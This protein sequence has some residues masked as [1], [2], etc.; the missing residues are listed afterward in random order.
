MACAWPSVALML[1][2]WLWRYESPKYL[3]AKGRT[4]EAEVVLKAIEKI[5]KSSAS[6][7]PVH[8]DGADLQSAEL[9]AKG[10]D[11]LMASVA[12][13][14]AIFFSQSSAYY[15]LTLWIG[16]FLRPWGLSSSLSMVFISLAELPGLFLTALLLR[17]QM[18]SPAKMLQVNFICAALITVLV[19]YTS[20]G[21]LAVL[22][23]CLLYS[24]IVSNWTLMYRIGKGPRQANLCSYT[25]M[26]EMFPVQ[27]RS[28]CFGA[29]GMAGKIGGL[30]SPTLFGI[31]MGRNWSTGDLHWVSGGLFLAGA[32]C[33]M[34][35]GK[36]MN[37]CGL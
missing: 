24:I 34:W 13:A 2:R 7:K 15:G 14:S 22:A 23:F 32:G 36:G 9:N 6:A 31:L 3:A 5:N 19:P 16:S 18:L 29:A 28:R 11:V 37:K 26:P 10:S 1:G 27:C 30:L 35:L 21:R 4:E 20:D 17:R 25:A 12:L 8:S 33:S